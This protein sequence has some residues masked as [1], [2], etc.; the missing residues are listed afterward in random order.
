VYSQRGIRLESTRVGDL[1]ALLMQVSVCLGFV[2]SWWRM[3]M[4]VA[5]LTA[6]IC[7]LS[8]RQ[9]GELVW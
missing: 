9:C 5:V 3:F 1:E 7:G 4:I 6:E 2:A 8:T